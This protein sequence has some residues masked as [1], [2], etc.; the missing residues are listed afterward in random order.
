MSVFLDSTFDPVPSFAHT[1]A[2]QVLTGSSLDPEGAQLRQWLR[3]P[4][5]R[6]T[7]SAL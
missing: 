4:S 7:A 2:V 5:F 3:G 6:A 1:T